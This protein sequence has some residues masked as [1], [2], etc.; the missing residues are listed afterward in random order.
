MGLLKKFSLSF[1]LAERGVHVA[2]AALLLRLPCALL[3]RS[4]QTSSMSCRPATFVSTNHEPTESQVTFMDQWEGRMETQVLRT[5]L[6]AYHEWPSNREGKAN[7][8]RDDREPI[9]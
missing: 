7:R 6:V 8:R 1:K 9:V 5:C 2:S 4:D 3:S